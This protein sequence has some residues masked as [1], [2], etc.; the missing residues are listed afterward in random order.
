M[1]RRIPDEV[2]EAVLKAYDIVDVVGRHVHL[3]KQG[4]YLKGLCPFHSEK[5]PSFTVT[6]EKQIY[7]CFG[8]H[9]GGNAIHFIMGVEGLSFGEAVRQM[10]E[11]AHIPVDWAPV[12]PE[13]T[14]EQAE[15][16]AL[17][18]AYEFTAKFYNYIML[19]TEQGRPALDYLRSRG[20]N[21]RI[22]ETF[23]LGYSP[24]MRDKL[25]EI[26]GKRGFD[27]AL[28]EKGGLLSHR[29]GSGYYDKFRDRIM[30]PIH[31]Q[32]G[33]I[34]AFGG[35]AMGDIQPKYMNSP[36]SPL[37]NKSRNLYNFH[38]ARPQIRKS[39]TVVLLEGY[40]DA[41]KVWEA[42]IQNGVASMGTALTREHALLLRRNADEA[43]LCYDGDPAGQN[44]AFKSI[45]LL[46]KEG[47][48]VKVAWLPGGQDPD[49][50]IT[51][52]GGERFRREIIEG[53]L[54]STKFKLQYIRKN[55][56]LTDV[57]GR[58]RYIESALKL[59]A[60]L[61]APY[62]REHYIQELASEFPYAADNLTQQM[63]GYRQDLLKKREPGDN[64]EQSWNNIR[65]NGNNRNKVSVLPAHEHAE[66]SILA[67]MLNDREAAQQ[68]QEELGD[69]FS[70]ELHAA[71]AAYL[72]AYY[73]QGNEPDISKFM[74]GLE[75]E[76]LERAAASLS[77]TDSQ[78]ALRALPDYIGY[79]KLYPRLKQLEKE[80]LEA[81]SMHDPLEAARRLGGIAQEIARVKKD[82]QA[83][84][85]QLNSFK[86]Y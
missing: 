78:P 13:Q 84:E 74:A 22:I 12:T 23:Q 17:Y 80:R 55:F 14:K 63:N 1:N 20:M 40:V 60:E 48:H 29:E 53:A 15:A 69:G 26:L 44:A 83:L 71:L 85:K 64:P 65:N 11:E 32:K 59:V 21:D 82:I 68:V 37:F 6:P 7:H 25:A 28:M 39:R 5:S 73:A 42:G 8:C 45:E 47:F 36:E 9:A 81:E 33:R 24:N 18:D 10:A 58:F 77:M 30:F 76:T 34:I 62:Q 4:H 16:K 46:E 57:D 2:I 43:L 50:F 41:I 79:L 49:E 52:F 72:Y 54:T 31:D 51:Q 56:N 75:D 61:D 70:T 3:S 67:A 66:I 19:N 27:L 35:R 38:Q 86:G